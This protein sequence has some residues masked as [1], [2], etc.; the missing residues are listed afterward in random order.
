M[1]PS[2]RLT[3]GL[4]LSFMSTFRLRSRDINPTAEPCR[5]AQASL[6]AAGDSFLPPLELS[7][8]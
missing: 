8:G 3:D 2:K 4:Q 5:A 7:L 6:P 1:A